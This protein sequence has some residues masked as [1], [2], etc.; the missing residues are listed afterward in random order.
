MLIDEIAEVMGKIS[1]MVDSNL[2]C[3]RKMLCLELEDWK[4]TAMKKSDIKMAYDSISSG[5]KL[6]EK[7]FAR[8][9]TEKKIF[10]EKKKSYIKLKQEG[11]YKF[12]AAAIC[13]AAAMAAAIFL[14]SKLHL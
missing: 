5:C 11:S 2:H 3:A 13:I 8:L 12:T 10:T 4:C 9:E 6:K 7:V 14:I 1:E